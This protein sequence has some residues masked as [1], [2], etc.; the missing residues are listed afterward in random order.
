MGVNLMKWIDQDLQQYIQA[1]EYVDTV[2]IPLTPFHF[3]NDS[4]ITKSARQKEA[5]TV[6]LSEIEKVLSGRILLSPS[7]YYLKHM[8]LEEE[9]KRVNT[10]IENAMEQPFKYVFL[11]TFDSKWKKHEE[12][13][14]GHLL[15]LPAIE[16]DFRSKEMASII[17]GQVDQIS[18][19]IQSYWS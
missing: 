5:L 6:L 15:W 3:T 18:E 12:L 17:R 11:V 4:M 14:N 9:S 19:F 2:L 1:K 8:N 16:G 13:L 7:Y 10:W